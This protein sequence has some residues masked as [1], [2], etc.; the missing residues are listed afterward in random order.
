[1]K[2][3]NKLPY[4][5]GLPHFNR[6]LRLAVTPWRDTACDLTKMTLAISINEAAKS[7]E[8]MPRRAQA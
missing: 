7:A 5:K 8:V 2:D 4:I 1:M 3:L 6:G